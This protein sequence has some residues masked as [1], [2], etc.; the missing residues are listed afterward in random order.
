MSPF[1]RSQQFLETPEPL[2]VLN[3][4]L[5]LLGS[6]HSDPW[7]RNLSRSRPLRLRQGPVQVLEIAIRTIVEIVVSED[8]SPLARPKP[9]DAL[10]E[11]PLLLV[12]VG[13][14]LL[15]LSLFLRRQRVV[16]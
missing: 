14:A 7:R 4:T 8:L 10:K 9:L 12:R 16:Y 5:F 3:Q 6:E 15:S 1:A 11:H 13:H 2:S